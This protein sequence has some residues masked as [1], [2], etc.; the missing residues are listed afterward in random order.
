MA[1]LDSATRRIVNRRRGLKVWNGVCGIEKGKGK[2][3]DEQQQRTQRTGMKGVREAMLVLWMS[4]VELENGELWACG[5][6]GSGRLGV[7]SKEVNVFVMSLVRV[8]E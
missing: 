7:G 6:N 3:V 4:F 5:F 8:V 2:G 1:N